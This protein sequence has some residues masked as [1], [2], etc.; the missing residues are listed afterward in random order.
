MGAIV[1]RIGL[2]AETKGI[3]IRKI[4]VEIGAS[5]GTL[6]KAIS[7]EKDVLSEWIAVFVQKFPDVN[8]VWLLTGEGNMSISEAQSLSIDKEN[9]YIEKIAHLEE[10]L[11][12][13][14]EK[15]KLLEDLIER[16]KQ[17]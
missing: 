2:Y 15:N 5:N 16:M 6:S 17:E 4:E 10:L 7:K 14:Q 9:A 8:P 11:K 3:S 13:H 12:V 1:N